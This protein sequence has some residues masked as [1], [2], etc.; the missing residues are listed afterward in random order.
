MG[1]ATGSISATIEREITA[2]MRKL[3]QSMANAFSFDA[4]VFA[5]AMNVNM[6]EEEMMEVMKRN[7]RIYEKT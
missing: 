2:S 3:S 6:S 5:D 1:S 7:H 4:S